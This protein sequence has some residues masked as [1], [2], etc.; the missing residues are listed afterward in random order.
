ME[1]QRSKHGHLATCVIAQRY[2]SA[3]S[4][5]VRFISLRQSLKKAFISILLNLVKSRASKI[6]LHEN[7]YAGNCV[8]GEKQ[9][10][11]RSVLPQ[12]NFL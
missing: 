11:K 5:S 6:A 7:A 4:V 3:T 1:N 12:T 2:S 9:E 8:C 10:S